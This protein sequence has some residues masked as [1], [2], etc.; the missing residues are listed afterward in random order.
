MH[1]DAGNG[2]TDRIEDPIGD[3]L[4]RR[5]GHR[6]DREP[7][8]QKHQPPDVD[9]PS[10]QLVGNRADETDQQNEDDFLQRAEHARQGAL[11]LARYPQHLGQ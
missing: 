2:H 9:D 10:A 11:F 1:H 7:G 3:E 8:G 6:V 4:L 5:L